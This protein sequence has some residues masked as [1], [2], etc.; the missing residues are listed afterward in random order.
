MVGTA[1]EQALSQYPPP[2]AAMPQQY[3]SLLQTS[4]THGSH[5]AAGTVLVVPAIHTLVSPPQLVP[6]GAPLVFCA[7]TPPL[8]SALQHWL[9]VVQEVLSALHEVPVP[10]SVVPA[11]AG[12]VV[13]KPPNPASGEHTCPEGHGAQAA[14]LPP[15][16]L[17]LVP[18]RH[19]PD[20][21]QPAGQLVELQVPP[22][23]GEPQTPPLQEREQHS[24]LNEQ[25][26]P[27]SLHAGAQKPLEQFFEQHC[28][29][30]SHAASIPLHVPASVPPSA[31]Q[32]PLLQTL[33]QHSAALRQAP[34]VDL[35][36]PPSFGFTVHTPLTHDSFVPHAWHA[37]PPVPHC[38]CVPPGLQ[39]PSASLHPLQLMH[40][41]PTHAFPEPEHTWHGAPLLPHA[42]FTLVPP[43][44]SH[45]P[46]LVQVAQVGSKQVPLTQVLPEPQFLHASPTPHAV[47]SSPFRHPPVEL[48]H[49]VQVFR[50][51]C[52]AVLP[53]SWLPNGTHTPA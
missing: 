31:T 51:F 37:A 39:A 24:E 30:S 52:T 46:P 41:P 49:P 6:M 15:Q 12:A 50:Q 29:L 18:L 42:V 47:V 8:H 25:V 10:A 7:Q 13:Q 2:P 1:P 45:C 40:V 11:S 34:P 19:T 9:L 3:G 23:G 27:L 48:Q 21:Q 53:G 16:L 33:L 22:S 4:A 28:E 17:L 44:G 26:S 35:H 5:D 38:P 20:E 14:P 43:L 36:I 32:R